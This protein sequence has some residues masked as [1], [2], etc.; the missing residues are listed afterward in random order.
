MVNIS[1]ATATFF[2]VPFRE[3]LGLIEKAG[4]KYIELDIYWQ[5]GDNWEAAQHLKGIKPKEVLKMVEDSG[6][7][8][9]SLHDIGGVIYKDSDSLITPDTYEYLEFGGESIPA[10]VF[11]T[12]HKKTQDTYWWSR[13]QDK[14]QK[15]LN[16]LK[17][18]Y[19]VCIENLQHFEGYQVPLLDPE[20]LLS[21]AKETG[22]F[23]NLD[24]TH[25]A[26][27]GTDIVNAA[28]VLKDRVKGIHFSDFKAGKTHLFPGE[29]VLDFK[30]FFKNLNAGQIAAMT[31][32]CNIPYRQG[33]PEVSVD[34]MVK[35]REY[36]L[37]TLEQATLPQI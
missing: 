9:N 36:L 18:K 12:P 33:E 24:T 17:D 15:D 37:N 8:I 5:G 13:Y 31:L 4:F 28:R 16:R 32:E 22:I 14:A 19:L 1:I 29:G 23:V 3:T 2:N 27:S 10:I 7:K 20:E 26:H 25:F 11:H 21:F 35:A 6:L 34:A 30:E